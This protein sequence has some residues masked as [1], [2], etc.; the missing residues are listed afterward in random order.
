MTAHNSPVVPANAGTHNPGRLWVCEVVQ[1]RFRTI[2]RGVWAPAFA[3]ATGE[4]S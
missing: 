3:G 2:G 1:Q 4:I